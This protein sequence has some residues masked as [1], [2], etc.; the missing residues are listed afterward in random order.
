MTSAVRFGAG[1]ARMRALKGLLWG[2]GDRAMLIQSGL[3]PRGRAI[4][5]APDQIFP[6]LLR[7]YVTLIAAYPSARGIFLALVRF[8]EIENVKLLWR[9]ALRRRPLPLECWRPLDPLST[10][11]PAFRSSSVEELG[12]RLASTPFRDIA[13]ALLR[14]SPGDLPATEIGLD[15]WAVRALH[16]EALRLPPREHAARDLLVDVCRERDVDLLRRGSSSYG[17]DPDL[18]AKSTIVLSLEH[19]IGPLAALATWRPDMGPLASFLPPRLLRLAGPVRDWDALAI[20]LRH[21]RLRACRRAFIGWPFE[22]SPPVSALLLREEQAR[23]AISAAAARPLP[24]PAGTALNT[25]LAA[26]ALES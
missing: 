25:V 2:V 4:S 11:P 8:H 14:S 7:W 1:Y 10:V 22:L 18:V 26:S 3:D 23:V 9:A 17:L 16:A 15:R 12:E 5:G 6:P 13:H 21:R 19:A 24:N 20:A